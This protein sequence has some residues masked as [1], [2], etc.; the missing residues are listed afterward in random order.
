MTI[1]A[2]FNP[3]FFSRKSDKQ[4]NCMLGVV[5]Y[6]CNPRLRQNGNEFEVSLRYTPRPCFKKKIRNLTAC[7]QLV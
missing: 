1:E 3:D 4:L 5:V 2:G 6:A 7:L